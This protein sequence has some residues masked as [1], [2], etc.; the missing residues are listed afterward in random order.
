MEEEVANDVVMAARAHW[1]DGDEVGGDEAG[2]DEA[3]PEA[4]EAE[5]PHE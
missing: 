3:A 4:E 1:F 5:A 2:G